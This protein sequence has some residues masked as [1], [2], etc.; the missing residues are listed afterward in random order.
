MKKTQISIKKKEISLKKG[1][2]KKTNNKTHIKIVKSSGK[3][4]VNGEGQTEA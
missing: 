3:S 4:K 1:S 2:Q